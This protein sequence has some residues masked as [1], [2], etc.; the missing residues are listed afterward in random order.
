IVKQQTTSRVEQ[1][2]DPVIRGWT[3]LIYWKTRKGSRIFKCCDAEMQGRSILAFVGGEK[4][5]VKVGRKSRWAP[6]AIG[7]RSAK[8]KGELPLPGNPAPVQTEYA[9]SGKLR[10]SGG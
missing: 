8:A 1:D 6:L 4:R 10:R 7:P 5:H 3:R 9:S 2:L